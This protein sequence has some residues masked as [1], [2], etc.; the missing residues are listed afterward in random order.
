MRIQ[1][2]VC[3]AAEAKVLCCADEAALCWACDEKI[4]A[5]NKLA[6]KHQRVPLS[7]SS[8]QMP[9]CDI[10][11]EASGFFFCLQDRALL[12]RKC[13][14]AIHTANPYVSS[15]QRFLLTGVKVGLETTDPGASSSD[16]KSPSSE[17][18][19]E[20]KT[21][22][23]S[24]RAAPMAFTGGYNEVLPS[25]LGDVNN[26]LTK[27]TYAGGSTAGSIQSWQMDDIFGLTDFNQSYGYM[28]DGSSKADSGKRGDSDSSSILRSADDEVDDDER[29]GQV[30]DSS[31]AVPQLPSPPTASGLYWPNDSRDQCDSVVFVPDICCSVMKN[32]FNSWRSGSNRKR[33]RHI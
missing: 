1:C 8:S 13:D 27:V 19:S 14:V 23:T 33:R 6:S 20:T 10:C 31:W 28:D 21:N 4:H 17:K 11:Q 32:P 26:E 9:K 22:S 30:P 18:T 7:S 2:N 29:L 25:N 3:E 15:H 24:R 12:C 5:A 16:V